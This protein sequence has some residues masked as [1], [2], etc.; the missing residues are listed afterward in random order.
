MPEIEIDTTRCIGCSQCV[1]FCPVEVFDLVE[2][3]GVNGRFVARPSRQEKCWACDTCA[4][5]CPTGAIYVRET[6][7]EMG[8]SKEECKMI[9][10]A[11]GDAERFRYADWHR[12]LRDILGLRWY[13]VAVS[14]IPAG[15]A[16]PDVPMPPVRLRHCQSIMAARRGY[17]FLMTPRWHACPDGTHIL[18]ITEIPPKLASGELYLRFGKIDSIEAARQMVKERPSLPGRSIAASVVTP[19]KD[20]VCTPDVVVVIANPEQSMW[21]C[22]AASYYSGR[23]FDFKV[24]GYNSLCVEA[25]VIPYTTDEINISLGCYGGRASSDVGDDQ[26]FVGIPLS[27]MARVIEGLQELGKKA[28]PDSRDKAYLPL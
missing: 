19:L 22:M 13:P 16:M 9:A 12:V 26:M 3:D 20:A 5:Q 25:T 8:V 11:I 14:L 10:P 6:E 18:G 28:I 27:R 24:S 17:S 15:S 21:L 1:D 4:G 23:R 7:A 2:T